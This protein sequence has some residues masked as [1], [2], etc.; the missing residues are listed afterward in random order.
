MTRRSWRELERAVESAADRR[1]EL[2]LHS[3]LAKAYGAGDDVD[4]VMNRPAVR[5]D[6]TEHAV[7]PD[8]HDRLKRLAEV[9]GE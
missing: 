4:V 2:G 6:G 5:V 9:G 3:V 7:D 1:D 8:A